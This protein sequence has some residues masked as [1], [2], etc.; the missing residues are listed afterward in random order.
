MLTMV[1]PM[2]QTL[3]YLLF[4]IL[5]VT[6]AEAADVNMQRLEDFDISVHK[7][8]VSIQVEVEGGCFIDPTNLE[9]TYAGLLSVFG[10]Q[11]A[12]VGESQ[13][14]FAVSIKGFKLSADQPCGLRVLSMVRQIPEIKMLRLSPGSSST[15]YRLWTAENVVTASASAIHSLLQEQAR[16]DVVD[17]SRTF[18]RSH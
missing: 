6:I 9:E 5:S 10:F 3:F 8:S 13:L 4:F 17:F 15:R 2:K 14:E 18:E 7:M 16:K 12:P 1:A 11:T